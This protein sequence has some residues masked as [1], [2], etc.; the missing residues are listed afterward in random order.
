MQK[1]LFLILLNSFLLSEI[2]NVPSDDYPTIQ[3]GIDVAQDGDTVLVSQGTYYENLQI[4]KSITLASH[5]IYDDL[6]NWSIEITP[7][8]WEVDNQNII[9]TI[10]DGSIVTDD[11][12]GS[13]IL[14]YSSDGD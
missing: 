11:D 3:S 8:S 10:I 13:A 6:T 7:Y 12:F 2:F 9:N 5:A 1:I 14:I 4:T